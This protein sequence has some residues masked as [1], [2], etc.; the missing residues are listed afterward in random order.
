[1]HL[2]RFKPLQSDYHTCSLRQQDL[3]ALYSGFFSV[4]KTTTSYT[5]QQ[6][7]YQAK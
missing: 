5:T 4:S 2:Q 1:M 3:H 7:A 6:H